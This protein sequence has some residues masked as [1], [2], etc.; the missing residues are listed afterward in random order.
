MWK[1]HVD[2]LG[3]PRHLGTG[4]Q[5]HLL[6]VSVPIQVQSRRPAR[7]LLQLWISS[8]PRTQHSVSSQEA[9]I[10]VLSDTKP[11]VSSLDGHS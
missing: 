9:G 7:L 2:T 6:Q 3:I 8:G 1:G 11:S 10:Y 4:S 5:V